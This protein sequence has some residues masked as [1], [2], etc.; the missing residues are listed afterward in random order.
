MDIVAAG[1]H[2]ARFFRSVFESGFFVD[3]QRIDIAAHCDAWRFRLR[4][5]DV[6]DDSGVRNALY[7]S[8]AEGVECVYEALG[9]VLFVPRQLRVTMQVASQREK[10]FLLVRR[11][12]RPGAG[13]GIG[14]RQV[15]S[16]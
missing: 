10:E 12:Q 7:V 11:E 2:D 15:V 4:S 16:R 6:P 8:R 9:R 13:Y 5:R 14:L 1:M 3:R